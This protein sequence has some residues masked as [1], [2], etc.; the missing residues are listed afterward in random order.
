M[1]LAERLRQEMGPFPNPFP[2]N[3]SETLERRN[4]IGW[5]EWIDEVAHCGW[6][7]NWERDNAELSAAFNAGLTTKQ[8]IEAIEQ[9][10]D[11]D[12]R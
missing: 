10:Q 8:A 1:R 6:G 12:A 2:T 5:I 4:G 11:E 9:I 3:V 7:F